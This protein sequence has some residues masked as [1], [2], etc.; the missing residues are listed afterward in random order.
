VGTSGFSYQGWKGTLYP[1]K[2]SQADYLQYYSRVFNTTEINNTFYRTPSTETTTRWASQ[3]PSGF[4]FTLKL[5]RWITHH[6]KLTKCDRE[7][8]EFFRGTEPLWGHLACL[9][10]QLSPSFQKDL[11]VLDDFLAKFSSEVPL[12][13]EFRHESWF[14]SEVYRLLE[15]YGAALVVV[16]TDDQEAVRKTTPLSYMLGC[17]GLDTIPRARRMGPLDGFFKK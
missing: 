2:L 15:Q 6:K 8:E 4:R 14:A 17:D 5:G 16:D 3:V 11:K 13:L 12:A 10:V 9:L 1:E 7:M